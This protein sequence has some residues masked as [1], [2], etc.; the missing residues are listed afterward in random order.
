MSQ[1]EPPSW[2]SAND[3]KYCS[4]ELY[5]GSRC[6][7]EIAEKGTPVYVLR[8]MRAI[9]NLQKLQKMIPDFSIYYAI[10]ANRHPLIVHGLRTAGISGID[11]CSPREAQLALSSGFHPEQISYTG[12]SMSRSDLDFLYSVPDIHVNVDSL[13]ALRRLLS[14]NLGKK[15]VRR[16]VGIRINPELGLGY[17]QESRLVYSGKDEISKFGILHEQIEDAIRLADLYGAVISTIHWHV[18]CGWLTEQLDQVKQVV[19]RGMEFAECF[20]DLERINLGGGL[21]VRLTEEDPEM[22]L[23]AWS[24]MIRRLN[25]D[26]WY[27]MIEP[28]AFLVQDSTILLVEICT[29]EKKRGIGFLGINAGFNLLIEPVFYGMPSEAVPL[30]IPDPEKP[31]YPCRFAG[32]INEAH[33]MLPQ[34]ITIPLPEEGDFFAL[35]NAGA[36]GTSMSSDHCLRQCT[37]EFVVD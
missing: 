1:T 15:H 37:R 17:H 9:Q 21:G 34:K 19:R 14:G 6:L 33:D 32:N 27:M 5:F 3:L 25:R 23:L 16:K 29:V 36:Y 13:A 12:T 2:W 22:D 10:K 30:K 18:G 7:R 26:R 35:L 11:V 31:K 4:G 28:G 20:P 8:P 24:E